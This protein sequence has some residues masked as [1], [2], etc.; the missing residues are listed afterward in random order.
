VGGPVSALVPAAR[1]FVRAESFDDMFLRDVGEARFQQPIVLTFGL[2]AFAISA[3]GLF[4]VVSYLVAQRTRDFG[5]RIALG[6]RA[7]H[8]WRSIVRESLMPAALGLGIGLAV[9]A[10]LEH[11]M[12]AS[13]FGWDSSGPLA[14]LTVA[15]ALLTVAVLA[16]VGPAR[17]VLRI[18]PAAAL[19]NE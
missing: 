15:L 2:F 17:R 18:D 10:G 11:V 12:R 19:R 3:V 4:G 7:S 1:P 14:M 16:A 9:A 6:A 13:V 5:I 8:L